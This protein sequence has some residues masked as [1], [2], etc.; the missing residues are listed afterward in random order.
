MKFDKIRAALDKI[1][2]GFKDKES[3]VGWFPGAAYPNGT[4]VAY[5]SIIQEM[6]AP[7]AGIP[8]RPFIRPTLSAR[9]TAWATT[10]KQG[11]KAKI[12][13]SMEATGVLELVGQQAAGDIRKTITQVHTPPLKKATVEARARRLSNRTI[14]TSL[15]KPLIDTGL[16]L[17]SLTSQVSDKE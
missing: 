3:K 8:A 1:P 15:Q 5:V 11:V 13:G 14:T 4:P 2:E 6:G 16:M 12:D 17:N 9:K 10:L 7:E